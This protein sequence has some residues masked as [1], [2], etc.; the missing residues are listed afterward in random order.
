VRVCA[1]PTVEAKNITLAELAL[2]L[3]LAAFWKRYLCHL[4]RPSGSDM[5]V[6]AMQAALMSRHAAHAFGM[7]P[8]RFRPWGG[9][10]WARRSGVGG[11]PGFD[12]KGGGV[13]GGQHAA[14]LQFLFGG[15][16]VG[17]ARGCRIRGDRTACRTAVC[18]LIR[19]QDQ[20]HWCRNWIAWPRR[21]GPSWG[22]H[23]ASHTGHLATFPRVRA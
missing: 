19:V 14:E 4:A 17:A 1:R 16:G 22:F 2:A 15:A 21:H 23:F 13:S 7:R 6:A 20:L 8:C 5:I 11:A 3:G 12:G 18:T 10:W 9:R